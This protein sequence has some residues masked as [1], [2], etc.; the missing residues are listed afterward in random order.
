[1]I[2]EEDRPSPR[3]PQ[4]SREIP[5]LLAGIRGRP[6]QVW[7]TA[8]GFAIGWAMAA[9]ETH[10]S[11]SEL[12]DDDG[13]LCELIQVTTTWIANGCGCS[14]AT[15]HRLRRDVAEAL[16]ATLVRAAGLDLLC[17]P[18]SL[19]AR[20]CQELRDGLR[21]ACR[22]A[23][24]TGLLPEPLLDQVPLGP[25]HRLTRVKRGKTRC[26][27]CGVRACAVRTH[28]DGH[29]T[30]WCYACSSGGTVVGLTIRRWDGHRGASANGRPDPG[31][32]PVRA[33]QWRRRERRPRSRGGR[34]RDRWAPDLKQRSPGG[35]E[36]ERAAPEPGR[37]RWPEPWPWEPSGR[38]EP[39]VLARLGARFG[40]RI[41]DAWTDP[42]INGRRFRHGR[43]VQVSILGTNVLVR[44]D[45]WIRINAH[46]TPEQ[47]AAV[48][49]VVADR[50]PPSTPESS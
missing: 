31:M 36:G 42:S 46:S 25:P 5:Q 11:L 9:P 1:M 41:G 16:G 8:L 35:G 10:R 45:G 22:A 38:R 6:A 3:A 2:P 32:P 40:L 18:R 12:R 27:W 17:D 48:R 7:H 34:L 33:E 13:E 44:G 20:V 37:P 43:H 19:L 24:E 26:P 14:I 15:A 21:I 50:V 29:R 47:A 39:E 4:W 49:R 23:A 30:G 28:E